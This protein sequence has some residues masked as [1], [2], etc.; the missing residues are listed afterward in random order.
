M[1]MGLPNVIISD[2]G[3]EFDNKLD[4]RL[5][6]LL[7]I[8]RRLT[9]PYHPQVKIAQFTEVRDYNTLNHYYIGKWIG[10]AMEP[11]NAA[12]V[13]EVLLQEDGGVGH[14]LGQLCVCIQYISPRIFWVYTIPADVQSASNI[15]H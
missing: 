14:L 3:R 15:T 6:N 8:K 11:N 2:N 10:G 4:K 1:R 5:A 7:G 12:D 9:T 13:S